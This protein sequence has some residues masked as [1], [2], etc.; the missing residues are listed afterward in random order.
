MDTNQSL[1]HISKLFP[2][3]ATKLFERS[4]YWNQSLETIVKHMLTS[5][6]G[7][8]LMSHQFWKHLISKFDP[9]HF[10]HDEKMDFIQLIGKLIKVN[11]GHE[12]VEH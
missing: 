9:Y 2:S 6:E 10:N 5:D 7:S 3:L 4:N 12:K 8:N 1:S 11:Y